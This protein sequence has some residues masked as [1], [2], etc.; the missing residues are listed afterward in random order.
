MNDNHAKKLATLRAMNIHRFTPRALEQFFANLFHEAE[1][2]EDATNAAFMA[3]HRLNGH[4]ATAA[5]FSL[6]TPAETKLPKR[7]CDWEGRYVRLRQPIPSGKHILGAG[8]ICRVERN[9]SGLHLV[10]V[11]PC[12]HCQCSDIRRISNVPESAVDLL[13]IKP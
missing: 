5:G 13:P 8:V 12:P 6:E 2:C 1:S 7:K 4:D 9:F 11:N 3:L 10:Q